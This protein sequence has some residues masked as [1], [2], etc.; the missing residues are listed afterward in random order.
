MAGCLRFLCPACSRWSSPGARS[1]ISA[2]YFEPEREPGR[3]PR[4]SGSRFEFLG[5]G[6]DRPETAN[7]ITYDDLVAITL[8]SVDVPG[9]VALKLLEGDLGPDIARHLER[10][11]ADV[12]IEEPAAANLFATSSH[13]RVAWDLLEEPHGMGW[14]ITGKLLARKRPRLIPVYDR[15]VRCAFGRPDGA[16][17][18]LLAMFAAEQHRL[19]DALV[20]ARQ[21]AGVPEGVS[22]LRVLDVIV[23]MRHRP[24]H[25]A[26]GCPGLV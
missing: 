22:P 21:E 7:R 13:A 5:G 26:T 20:T 11:P 1:T 3:P 8:L 2:A 23:W 9:D 6:G 25:L 18:W 14:V 16:W 15:V 10:I 19:A 17:N 12:G 4:Y 24:I